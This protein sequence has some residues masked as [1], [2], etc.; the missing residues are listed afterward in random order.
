MDINRLID[1]TP[2]SWHIKGVLLR[3]ADKQTIR[4]AINIVDKDEAMVQAS[5][6]T[7]IANGRGYIG[8]FGVPMERKTGIRVSVPLLLTPRVP[9]RER[10]FAFTRVDDEP[11]K[12]QDALT[13]ATTLA[14]VSPCDKDHPGSPPIAHPPPCPM[15]PSRHTVQGRR[16]RHR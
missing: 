13:P 10:R 2:F 15:R 12:P 8:L 6:G 3:Q 11:N 9:K 4:V 14:L 7:T 16:D 1:L 5:T